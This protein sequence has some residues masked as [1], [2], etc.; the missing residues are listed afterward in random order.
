MGSWRSKYHLVFQQRHPVQ[1]AKTLSLRGNYQQDGKKC[2]TSDHDLIVWDWA[3]KLSKPF[4]FV[5]E[6]AFE[7]ANSKLSQ[8][9][10]IPT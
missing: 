6:A 4:L 7:P 5:N 2:V 1:T 10:K 9:Y 8:P 3:L